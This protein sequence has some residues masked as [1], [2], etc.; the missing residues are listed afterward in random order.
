[1]RMDQQES[2]TAI[3]ILNTYT[4]DQLHKIFGVYGEVTNA[5]TLAQNIVLY[6]NNSKIETV[7][8]LK[9]IAL[10]TKIKG[11]KSSQYLAQVFQ[12]IRIE[13]NQEMEALK[14]LLTQSAEIIR[15]GGRLVIISYHS[16]EDRLVKNYIQKG[17]FAGN[18]EKDLYGNDL[19]PFKAINQKAIIASDAEIE[20]NSRA[21]SA[22][23]RIAEKI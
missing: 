21:R 3:D 6:R 15:P 10:N 22:K 4:Q 16:L 1:M 17:K 11:V 13:V 14:E 12:A 8:Q 18:V 9:S 19:K 20:Q 2:S 5:K 7:E 23:L